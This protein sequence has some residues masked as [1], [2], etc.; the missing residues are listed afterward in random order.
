MVMQIMLVQVLMTLPK[1][2]FSAKIKRKPSALTSMGKVKAFHMSGPRTRGAQVRHPTRITARQQIRAQRSRFQASSVHPRTP[3][4]P[5]NHSLWTNLVKTIAKT[6]L[7]TPPTMS[8]SRTRSS[9]RP[10]GIARSPSCFLEARPQRI[11]RHLRR[12]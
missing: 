12:I 10:I 1:I 8:R 11:R 7:G 4:Q 5:Q 6:M 3:R 2:R 9:K